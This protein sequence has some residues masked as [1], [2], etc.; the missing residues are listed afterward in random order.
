MRKQ[1][2]DTTIA[3][4]APWSNEL[5]TY[6]EGHLVTYLRLLDA[7]A[8]GASGD[9]MARIILGIDPTTEHERAKRDVA[10]H[11][12][13]ARWMTEAGYPPPLKHVKT[14]AHQTKNSH[15]PH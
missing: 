8:E 9:E 2:S 10:S 3:D 13:R 5:T 12:W 11:L 7:S 14:A 4:E 1:T 15:K 6:D